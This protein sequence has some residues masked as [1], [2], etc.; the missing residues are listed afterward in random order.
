M[1]ATRGVSLL[2]H[3]KEHFPLSIHYCLTRSSNKSAYSVIGIGKEGALTE[4]LQVVYPVLATPGPVPTRQDLSY[5][6]EVLLEPTEKYILMNDLG[7]DLVRV[8][9]WDK[10][11]LA[12]LTEHASLHTEAAVGPRHGVFWKSP[13]GVLHYFFVGELSQNVYSYQIHYNSTG[14]L[15]W[16]KVFEI[17]ALGLAN[18]KPALTSPPSEIALTPDN[19]F[20]MVSNRDIS[21]PQ[22][23]IYASGPTDTISTFSIHGN[24]TLSLLQLAPSGGWLPRQFSLNKKGDMIAIG[25][26]GNKS[27]VVWKRDLSSGKIDT[28]APVGQV[29]LTGP[30]VATVWD[31]AC[32]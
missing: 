20:I 30:V 28:S 31:E 10:A 5:L 8:F 14:G 17:P 3:S 26:Q 21:F 12:P 15:Y 11:S 24:G 1:K 22:S 6:H 7:A 16:E 2:L 27:V 18:A 23:M 25:H 13:S 4:P 9:T 19:K 32:D 29:I